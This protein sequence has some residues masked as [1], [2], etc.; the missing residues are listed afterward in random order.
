MVD[1]LKTTGLLCCGGLAMMATL[2]V[3]PAPANAGKIG[4]LVG[5]T[6]TKVVVKN[7]LKS[8]RKKNRDNLHEED[9]DSK[10]DTAP[11]TIDSE[12][13]AAHAKAMLDAEKSKDAE[14]SKTEITAS[15]VTNAP[16]TAVQ[17]AT[18]LA[19]C[20]SSPLAPRS[21]QMQLNPAARNDID[22]R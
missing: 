10:T 3:N 5:K 19:G 16:I 6:A 22:A 21:A 2:I 20:Y 11:V 15:S 1:V 7:V 9:D 18:C 13:R 12:A 4:S 14:T 8:N 17:G